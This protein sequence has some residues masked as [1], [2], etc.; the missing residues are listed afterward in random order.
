GGWQL[1]RASCRPSAPGSALGSGTVGQAGDVVV[2]YLLALQCG[3]TEHHGEADLRT[4]IDVGGAELVAEK[5]R[6]F[7]Q[8]RLER[9]HD[10]LVAAPADGSL[11][12]H[13][14]AVHH[15]VEQGGLHA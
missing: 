3:R 13:G 1:S 8:R 14:R 11:T 6:P 12:L 4:D 5:V 9:R 15:L 7:G 10:L 2:E